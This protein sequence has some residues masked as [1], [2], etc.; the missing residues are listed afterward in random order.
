M[1]QDFKIPYEDGS[2]YTGQCLRNKPHGKGKLV[3]GNGNV[4]EGLFQ[5]GEP[6]N[7]TMQYRTGAKYIGD[8]SGGL[9]HGR[10]ILHS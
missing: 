10:G 5:L 9:P 4:F 2:V 6:H 3:Y 7:G 8:V 1:G